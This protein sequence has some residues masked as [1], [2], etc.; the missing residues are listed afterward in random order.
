MSVSRRAVLASALAVAA[1][2][3]AIAAEAKFTMEAFQAAQAAGRSIL[4]E[5]HADWCPVCQRQKPI[6]SG[7]GA[8]PT[9]AGVLRL[10]V[11]F[12]TQ[13]DVLRTFRVTQQSTLIAFKGT[14]ERARSVGDTNAASLRALMQS[15][16]S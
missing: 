2:R 15:S 12:D 1:L 6:L 9:F 11:D 16:L 5:V 13:K 10:V 14:A 7:L 4:V 8:E 3:P